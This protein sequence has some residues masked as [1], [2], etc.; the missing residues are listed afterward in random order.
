M[1]TASNDCSGSQLNLDVEL[2]QVGLDADLHDIPFRSAWLIQFDHFNRMTGFEL[3]RDEFPRSG[4]REIGAEYPV[5]LRTSL[6]RQLTGRSSLN[7]TLRAS[8]LLA[9]SIS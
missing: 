6:G 3:G 7:A 9:S 8:P 2:R 4:I 5:W 1:K